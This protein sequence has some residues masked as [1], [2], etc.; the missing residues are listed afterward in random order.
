MPACNGGNE[1][2]AAQSQKA[3]LPASALA[4]DPA[5]PAD[6]AQEVQRYTLKALDL[7][8]NWIE[9]G[10]KDRAVPACKWENS[11][12]LRNSREKHS[13]SSSSS[14][15]QNVG[16]DVQLSQVPM[17]EEA[18]FAF[19]EQTLEDSVNPWTHRFL[20]KLYTMP[21]TLSPA[22]ELMLGAMNASGVVSSAS[23]ALCLAEE[24]AVEGLARLIGW[25]VDKVD[26]LTMPGGSSSNVLAV[27][28]ALGNAFPSFK[29][30][31]LFGVTEHLMS[32]GRSL[33]ASRPIILTSEQSHYSIEKAALAC[34]MGLE[35]VQKVKCDANGRINL[36]HLDEVLAGFEDSEETDSSRTGFPFYINLTAGTT[37][38]GAFD[39][40][41]GATEVIRKW[42][43]RRESKNSSSNGSSN[44]DRSSPQL[45]TPTKI[46]IHIDASWGGPVLFSS[47]L[48]KLMDGVCSAD[49]LTINPHKVLNITQQCSFAL[50]RRASDL[51]VNVTGAKYLFHGASTSSTSDEEKREFLRRNPGAK[52]MGCGRR[53]DAFKFYVEWLRVSTL[54][55]A[56]HVERGVGYAYSLVR[57]VE[58]RYAATLEVAEATLAGVQTGGL[59][60]QV[61]FRPRLPRG[62]AE[63]FKLVLPDEDAEPNGRAGVPSRSYSLLS[64][65]TH[66]LH[67]KLRALGR[68]TVD[69]A[70]LA[71]PHAD[72]G[73]Y[74]R[75]VAHPTTSLALYEEL[76]GEVDRLG[77]E[78]FDELSGKLKLRMD[79][80][81]GVAEGKRLKSYLDEIAVEE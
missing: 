79:G 63:L 59:F 56:A 72:V 36:A 26:G 38:L 2:L 34:G 42:E 54:G 67:A 23:P 49:S 41:Q 6:S 65:S 37:I 4:A 61:C 69:K 44:G 60:L 9:K 45:P 11:T 55:F 21:T 47:S 68:F 77:R 52:T 18:I 30:Q 19:L 32:T 43:A 46:W 12:H 66:A 29:R 39:D 3:P 33:K 74:I 1:V 28:T 71:Y 14:N 51:T 50:F 5:S 70:P 75:L 24:K 76:V 20:D 13:S 31:G 7:L 27:Q 57:L 8:T 58:E 81:N 22:L 40:I 15:G 35:S 64:H 80:T 78:Y 16:G 48:R 25:D 17:S 53:P 10:E 73:Y 62:I